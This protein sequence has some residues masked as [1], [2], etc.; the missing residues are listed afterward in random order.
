MRLTSPAARKVEIVSAKQLAFP[1]VAPNV[2]A[3]RVVA[4]LTVGTSRTIRAYFDAVL[5]QHG[6]M[7]SALVV[8]SLGA[9]VPVTQEQV[10][11]L[12]LAGRMAEAA[13]PKGP[14][15]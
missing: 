10:L 6:Q 5:L 2:I 4:T 8:T 9:A 11:A 14:V 12:I 1:K 7:Q 13:K 3:Y 15:A